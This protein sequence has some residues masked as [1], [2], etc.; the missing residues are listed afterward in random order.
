MRP[1]TASYPDTVGATQFA[2]IMSDYN[3]AVVLA[4]NTSKLVPVPAGARYVAYSFDGDFWA[5]AGTS[6]ITA[7]IPGA[8]TTDGTGA[9]LNP[10]QRRIPDGITH[11]ALIAS[12]ARLGTLSFWG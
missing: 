5:K 1:F 9:V 3:E 8:T 10:T 7:A 2:P 4:A 11:L 6:T 12:A